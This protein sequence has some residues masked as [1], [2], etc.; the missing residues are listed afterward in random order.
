MRIET[1]LTTVT[2]ISFVTAALIAGFLS[3]RIEITQAREEV[4][5]TAEVLIDAASAV[6]HYTNDEITPLVADLADKPFAPQQVPA[7]AAQTAMVHLRAQYPQF[8]YHEASVNPTNTADRASD[9][10]A[11]LLQQ[12]RV[13]G[14]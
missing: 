12:L 11:G 6:R 1:R 10:E 7:Y 4:N 3:Y 8:R 2:A 9:W 14:K 5:A 13:D